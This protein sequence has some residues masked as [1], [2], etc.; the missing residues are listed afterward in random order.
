MLDYTVFS[1]V[2]T[3][4]PREPS[5]LRTKIIYNIASRAAQSNSIYVSVLKIPIVLA[6]SE[7]INTPEFF[8]FFAR[9]A[10]VS[11]GKNIIFRGNN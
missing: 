4:Q 8:F 9:A 3:E 1:R 11:E 2:V 6:H 10:V 7:Q 5:E